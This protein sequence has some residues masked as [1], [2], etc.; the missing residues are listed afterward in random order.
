MKSEWACLI[1]RT[2]GLAMA[3]A[4]AGCGRTD[5]AGA[6]S[7]DFAAETLGLPTPTLLPP[8]GL[9]D[10]APMP[11]P[12][13]Q[14]RVDL[15]RAFFAGDFATIDR[16]LTAAHAQYTQGGSARDESER[17]PLLIVDAGTAGAE[18]CDQ[19][20]KSMPRSYVAFRLCGR[21][22]QR[23]AWMARTEQTADKITASQFALMKDR[24]Q[25]SNRLLQQALALD[26][27]PVQA[28]TML[29]DN[30][31]LLKEKVEAQ[32]TLERAMVMMPRHAD[33][34]EVTARYARP[35]WGSSDKAVAAVVLRARR[36]GVEPD[37]ITYIE[38]HSVARP[39]VTPTPGAE[40]LY[41][42]KVIAERA[43]YQRL[44]DFAMYYT[45]LSNWRDA[46]P[47]LERAIREHSHVAASYYWRA[48]SHEE[49]GD[50]RA[51]LPDYRL[52]AA[53]G[54]EHAIQRLIQ[55]HIQGALGLPGRNL[56]ALA[57]L[58]RYAAALGS[59]AGGNCL[60]SSHWD[61]SLPGLPKDPSLALA[62][63]AFA[64]R[65]GSANSQHDLGWL[66]M[67]QRWPSLDA[68]TAKAAGIF[69]LQRAAEQEHGFAI[70]KLQEAGIAIE[71]PAGR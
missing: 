17:L 50:G 22:W 6:P 29:A 1:A 5:A 52:A 58:C 69:W 67:S 7:R 45:R 41:W 47:V 14:T 49:L 71:R 59:P 23:G 28:L 37:R 43:T 65:G 24:L 11:A 25:R 53:M 61:G 39:W 42:E 70:R 51:A 10:A 62:W 26:A 55:A 4:S 2:L 64:A 30:Q 60:G 21:L 3:V 13:A 40:K 56:A 18:R 68:A 8:R 16:A 48:R 32:A 63:H 9:Q 44:E 34:Y 31:F 46:L 35:E 38:D 33:A 57:E 20:L 19:W 66:L 12:L 27:K 54:N 15:A 36:A